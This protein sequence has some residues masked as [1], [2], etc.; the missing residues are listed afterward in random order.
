MR[1]VFLWIIAL[2]LFG[3]V[4]YFISMGE[5]DLEQ[6]YRWEIIVSVTLS[7]VIWLIFQWRRAMRLEKLM[8][9]FNFW[10]IETLTLSN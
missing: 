2:I 4:F 10:M 9:P 5:L 1:S 8:Y 6:F 3:S 7:T